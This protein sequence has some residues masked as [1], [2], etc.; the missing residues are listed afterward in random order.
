MTTWDKTKWRPEGYE[1]S[2]K[3][4]YVLCERCNWPTDVVYE[5]A[6]EKTGNHDY[7]RWCPACGH[8]FAASK[9]SLKQKEGRGEPFTYGDPTY[10][11]P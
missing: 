7:W 1:A 6:D 2:Y 10:T 9:Y 11:P 4:S 5:I 3:A 8:K